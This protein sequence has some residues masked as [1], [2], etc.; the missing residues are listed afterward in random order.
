MQRKTPR[1]VETQ[2]CQ[3]RRTIPVKANHSCEGQPFHF[4]SV[5]AGPSGAGKPF[6]EDAGSISDSPDVITAVWPAKSAWPIT[7]PLVT[8]N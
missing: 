4:I 3:C 5:Q 8:E 6:R 7:L 2:R 1:S